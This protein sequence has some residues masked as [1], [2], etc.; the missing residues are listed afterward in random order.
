M[1]TYKPEDV[2]LSFGGRTWKG[3]SIEDLVEVEIPNITITDMSTYAKDH[4][5]YSENLVRVDVRKIYDNEG[6]SYNASF[7]VVKGSETHNQ[8]AALDPFD[9]TTLTAKNVCLVKSI[10]EKDE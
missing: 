3:H 6:N 10:V 4:P 8:I 1:Q 2:S 5:D 7:K 9:C